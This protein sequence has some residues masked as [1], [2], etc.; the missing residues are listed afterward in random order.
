MKVEL[1][2]YFEWDDEKNN[3]LKSDS[4]RQNI[5]FESVVI[6]LTKEENLLDYIDSPTHSGQ[7]CYVIN[8][9]DYV[10][11]VPFVQEGNKIFLETIYPSRKYTKYYLNK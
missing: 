4:T 10:Y 3:L 9:N 11:I 6:A 1:D 5:S 8:I 2:L 7:K